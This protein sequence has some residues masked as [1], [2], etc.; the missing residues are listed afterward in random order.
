[1]GFKTGIT[2]A[3]G[4][5]YT[6]AYFKIQNVSC[7]D[8]ANRRCEFKLSV[9]KDKTA[10]DAGKSKLKGGMP[11]ITRYVVTGDDFDAYF[12]DS[13]LDD[14]DKNITKQCYAY[15]KAQDDYSS[16]TDIDPDE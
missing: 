3:D 7:Y 8:L 2:T 12:A 10:R 13:I 15:A 14:A 16:V 5:E 4:T 11:T 9:Y 6:D 1:M